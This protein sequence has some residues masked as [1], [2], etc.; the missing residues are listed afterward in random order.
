MSLFSK[1]SCY[2]SYLN[3]IEFIVAARLAL[4]DPHSLHKFVNVLREEATCILQE[5]GLLEELGKA[6]VYCSPRSLRSVGAAISRLPSD[7]TESMDKELR[8]TSRE[9]Q[10]NTHWSIQEE[11]T[12]KSHPL[13]YQR[14]DYTQKQRCTTE[15]EIRFPGINYTFPTSSHMLIVVSDPESEPDS[16][17]VPPSRQDTG[18][19]PHISTRP[20]NGF[21]KQ[22]MVSLGISGD[23]LSSSDTMLIRRLTPEAAGQES[24]TIPPPTY[25]THSNILTLL[26][27]DPS[28]KVPITSDMRSTP[29]VQESQGTFNLAVKTKL[30]NGRLSMRTLSIKSGSKSYLCT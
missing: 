9:Q 30:L 24:H 14:P 20:P 26:N 17:T 6:Y 5:L 4:Q 2:E 13:I 29:T 10:V 7:G 27:G 18:S 1:L 8:R 3:C 22:P 21:T 28:S 25:Q 12:N 16:C 15:D 11:P 23:L 19:T